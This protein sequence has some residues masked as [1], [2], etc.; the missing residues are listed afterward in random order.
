MSFG[1]AWK[2]WMGECDQAQT[3]K[4]LDYFY[5]KGGNF[6]DTSNNYQ[7]QQS[8]IWIGEWMKQR[9]NRDEIVL[10]TKY[11]TPFRSTHASSEI[12]ADTGGNGAKSLRHSVDASLKKLQTDYID[13]LYVH[14]YDHVT[15]IEEVMQSLNQ[16]VL[17]GK[18]LYLGISDCPA[19]VVSKA[20]Q[21][22]RDHGMRQFVVYQGKWSAADRDFERDIIPMC[23]SENMGFAPWGALGGGA[24]KTEEARKKGEGRNFS[25]MG[26]GVSE[27]SIDV[28]KVLEKIANEKKTAIT[29]VALAYVMHKTPYVFPIIGG[30]KVEY[31]QSNIE[32]L[33]LKLSPEDIAEIEG[34]T[35][36]DL[37]FPLNMISSDPAKNWLLATGEPGEYV[38]RPK[39]IP[40]NQDIIDK[41]MVF[42]TVEP[43]K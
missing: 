42:R 30:S 12:L 11:S 9:G 36:F 17:A 27:K 15:S 39:A 43:K 1:T 6:I 40:P 5:E 34:A 21:Y 41:K 14:W 7:D 2:G 28:S 31:L 37:G 22:A 23:I 32:A 4:I 26:R 33:S 38:A 13:I 10:A 3:E 20:N 19:W 25:A 24:F 16:L 35:P 8:E 18:V 29:S